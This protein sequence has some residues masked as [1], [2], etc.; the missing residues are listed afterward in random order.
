MLEDVVCYMDKRGNMTGM[1]L[2]YFSAI[3]I[4]D[5][6][7]GKRYENKLELVDG[8]NRFDIPKKQDTVNLWTAIKYIH[9]CMYIYMH[10]IL[11]SS[12]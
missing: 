9:T 11:T 7:S 12:P 6:N 10:L 3:N 2:G 4:V 8:H 5:I 1:I